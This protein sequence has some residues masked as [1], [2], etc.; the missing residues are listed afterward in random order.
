ML[1][2]TC[3]LCRVDPLLLS[4]NQPRIRLLCMTD[5]K[6]SFI[7]TNIKCIVVCERHNNEFYKNEMLDALLCVSF[8]QQKILAEKK[9]I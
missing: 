1:M 3:V 6:M 7:Q 4:M 8:I 9:I 2:T 5:T